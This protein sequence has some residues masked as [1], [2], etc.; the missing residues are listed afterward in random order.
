MVGYD[1][2]ESKLAHTIINISSIVKIKTYVIAY[3]EIA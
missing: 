1:K 2:Q 3:C